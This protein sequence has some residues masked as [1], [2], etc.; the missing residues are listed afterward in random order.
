MEIIV[1]AALTIS[2]VVTTCGVFVKTTRQLI[3]LLAIQAAVIGLV[4]LMFC[5]VNLLMGLGFEGLIDFFATFAEWFS[6]AVVSPLIIYWG[7]IKTENVNSQPI[8]SVKRG[9]IILV[10]I[11][12]SNIVL[13]IFTS[14]LLPANIESLPFVSI[15]FSLSVLITATRT[16]P[17]AILVGLNMAENSFYPIFAESPLVLIPFMLALMVFVNLVGIFIIIEAYR[18]Y[19][20]M[21]IR[22][23]RWAD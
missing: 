13:C 5:L 6:S 9:G 21:S 1:L 12:V 22:K 7:M 23:W 19:G 18:D 16:D 3:R 14:S 8:V 11:I 20:T 4:E 15:M 2:V 10:A 17:L